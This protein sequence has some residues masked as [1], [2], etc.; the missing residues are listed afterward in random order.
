[1]TI[2]SR[3]HGAAHVT[4]LCGE[5]HRLVESQEQV[6]TLTYVDTLEE[7]TLLES[8]LDN[9]KPPL[10]PGASGLHYL[11]S[12]PFRY[13]PLRW[14]SR[15]GRVHERGIFYGGL[16][17]HTTLAESAYYRFALEDFQVAGRLPMPA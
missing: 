12:T 11:L 13:P 6:A 15:F 9:A 5:V 8:M 16:S 2:W 14:G 7:Q 17:R 4:P 1:V 10:P 3:Y